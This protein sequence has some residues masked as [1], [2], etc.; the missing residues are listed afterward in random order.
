MNSINCSSSAGRTNS[1]A[2]SGAS[3]I[4]S[5]PST[6][7]RRAYGELCVERMCP[8]RLHT[9]RHVMARAAGKR[10]ATTV[11]SSLVAVLK[12]E[13]KYERESYR[14]DEFL[15]QGPPCNFELQDAKGTAAF[16]LTKQFKDEEIT[17]R[18]NLD[19]GDE[20]EEGEDAAELFGGGDDDEDEEEAPVDFMV[21]IERD[22]TDVLVFECESNGEYLTIKRVAMH[23]LLEEEGGVPPYR[24]PA[25]NDL[26]DTLQQAFVDFLEER[27]VNAVLGWYIR[28]YMADKTALEYQ[29][30]LARVRDFVGQ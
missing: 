1:L 26:D 11:S 18:V 30:W 2:L 20:S 15:T 21:T 4:V 12:D 3:S 22:G 13:I 5:L 29:Q 19:Q 6:S 9:A 7:G 16:L 25:F 23:N 24:G 10:T 8:M 28:T 14:R 17:V 27:G